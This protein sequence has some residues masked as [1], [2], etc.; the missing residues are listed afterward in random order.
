[1]NPDE[2]EEELSMC[3]NLGFSEVFVISDDT[4][5]NLDVTFDGRNIADR[6]IISEHSQ[7]TVTLRDEDSFLLLDDPADLDIRLTYPNL[8]EWKADP[9]SEMSQWTPASSIE[10]N[11]ATY[12]LTPN[13]DQVGVYQL[14]IKARDISGNIAEDSDPYEIS[15]IVINEDEPS[16]LLVS[17]NPMTSEALFEYVI[18]SDRLPTVFALNIYASDGKIIRSFSADDFGGLGPGRNTYRWDGT[19]QQGALVP[20]GLYYYEIVDNLVTKADRQIGGLIKLD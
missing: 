20:Q 14:V 17:P 6:E 16:T 11:E 12:R 10:D 2:A 18:D 19:S 9:S 7:I 5:P 15:F 3:N 1:V 4:R 8:F 13:L